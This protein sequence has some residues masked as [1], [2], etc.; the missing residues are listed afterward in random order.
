MTDRSSRQ[1]VVD[2]HL[3]GKTYGQISYATG[4]SRGCIGGHLSRWRADNGLAPGKVNGRPWTQANDLTLARHYYAGMPLADIAM[5][6][7]RTR[8]AVECRLDILRQNGDLCRNQGDGEAQPEYAH[9]QRQRAADA[10]FLRALARAFR[11]GDHL[12]QMSRAA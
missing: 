6:I 10:K 2:L 8:S 11:R 7:G 5:L 1:W 9:V 3:Q 12:P 4:L